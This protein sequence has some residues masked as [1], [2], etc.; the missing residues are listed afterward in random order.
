MKRNQQVVLFD[1]PGALIYFIGKMKVL[2]KV[3]AK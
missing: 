1:F 3:A 2:L